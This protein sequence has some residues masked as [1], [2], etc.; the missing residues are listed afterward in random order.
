[1]RT[2]YIFPLSIIATL[3]ILYGDHVLRFI[4]YDGVSM[5]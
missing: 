4:H 5:L 3:T 2:Y 1:M